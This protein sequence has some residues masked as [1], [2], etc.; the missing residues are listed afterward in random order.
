MSD[1]I[2]AIIEA[3]KRFQ[4]AGVPVAP[5]D[6][7]AVLGMAVAPGDGADQTPPADTGSPE[8]V[9]GVTVLGRIY[10]R[11]LYPNSQRRVKVFTTTEKA[12]IVG[13]I[14]CSGA[15]DL[16]VMVY[17]LAQPLNPKGN[18]Y[19]DAKYFEYVRVPQAVALDKKGK[20]SP[21]L[22]GWITRDGS[23]AEIIG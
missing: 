21:S 22:L 19:Q 23:Q 15:P 11:H 17:R 2:D 3:A 9:P 8:V 18:P 10:V 12:D 13:Y 1:Q 5:I 20:P 16:T 6:V 14:D 4:D 7:P